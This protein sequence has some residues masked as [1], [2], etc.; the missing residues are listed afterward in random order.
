MVVCGDLNV[1]PDSTT[2][3]VLGS[4]GLTDLVGKRDTRTSRYTKR[5]RH[6]SYALV[7]EVLRVQAFDAPAEPEVS[8]H[9]PLVLDL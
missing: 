3:D 7:S 4:I 1:L 5:S 2:F 6:A 8:D 9:R